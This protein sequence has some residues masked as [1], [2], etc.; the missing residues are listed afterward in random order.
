MPTYEYHCKNCG[1]Q[2]EELQSIKDSPLVRCPKCHKNTLVRAIG[3]GGG[4]IFKGSG[5]Y[6]TDYK[7]PPAPEKTQP[8]KKKEETKPGSKPAAKPTE[9]KPTGDSTTTPPK[10]R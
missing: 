5:F 2:M 10:K 4:L 9:S 6:L 7:N 8:E 1:H 3:G